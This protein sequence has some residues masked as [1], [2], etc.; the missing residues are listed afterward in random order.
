MIA[1]WVA[2]AAGLIFLAIAAGYGTY[3]LMEW[4]ESRWPQQ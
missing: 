4:V 2:A 1:A 3:Y